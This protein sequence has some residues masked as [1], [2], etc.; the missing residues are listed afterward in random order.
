MHGVIVDEE[1]TYSAWMRESFA[2]HGCTLAR[3]SPYDSKALVELVA[4][5]ELG[6]VLLPHH[7]LQVA[8]LREALPWL[9]RKA[10]YPV[11][12][13]V[14]LSD[15]ETHDHL[16]NVG[17]ICVLDAPTP[18]EEIIRTALI[19]RS[20]DQSTTPHSTLSQHSAAAS[21]VRVLVA[22]DAPTS[23][24]IIREILEEGGYIV[25]TVE[26]GKEALARLQRENHASTEAPISV[27]LTD[28]EMPEMNGME[29][30]RAL[31][32]MESTTDS[33][34]HLPIIAITAHALTDEQE[35]M[36][37]SGIDFIL[38]KPLNPLDLAKAL[39]NISTQSSS[40]ISPSMSPNQTDSTRVSLRT[41]TERL[42]REVSL[43]NGPTASSMP[44]L[45]IDIEDVLERSGDSPRRTKMI[46]QAFLDSYAEHLSRIRPSDTA[47]SSLQELIISAHSLK[48]LLLD[49]GAK[50]TASLAASIEAALKAGDELS[51]KESRERCGAQ[52]DLVAA[53]AERL[54]RHFPAL[55]FR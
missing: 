12:A 4:R 9:R 30:A 23:R 31:R 45:A 27:V 49:V 33:Q 39:S 29:L 41:L 1:T 51:V 10:P 43:D 13:S 24:L 8:E 54:V 47:A 50:H 35:K 46:L 52:I 26:N 3:V 18:A 38:T 37:A 2:R 5:K 20:A 14:R 36:R 17:G 48:G 19:A 25:E 15:M 34:R 7:A 11:I 40:P 16:Q 21:P 32:S 44:S 42:W 53:L 22:D 6:F 55:E 28:I